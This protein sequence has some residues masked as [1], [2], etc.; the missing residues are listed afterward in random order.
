MNW[1]YFCVGVSL[2]RIVPWY[3]YCIDITSVWLCYYWVMLLGVAI[4]LLSLWCGCDISRVQ[5]CYYYTMQLVFFFK[6]LILFCDCVTISYCASV[7]L[8]CCYKSCIGVLLL[9]MTPWY[10]YYFCMSVL[11]LSIAPWY[12]YFCQFGS[13][14]V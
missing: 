12:C 2:L 8:L 4:E 13:F 11:L 1:Y 14:L 10:C 9:P 5:L 6:L 3:C 7:L